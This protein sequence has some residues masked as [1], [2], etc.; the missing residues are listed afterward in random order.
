M[1]IEQLDLRPGR[2]DDAQAI[3]AMSRDLIEN[4]L[5]WSWTPGRVSRRLLH[6]ECATVVACQGPRL[7]AFGLMLLG[8]DIGHL[9][10]LAVEPQYQRRGLGRQ[11]F[12]WLEQTSRVAGL[13]RIDVEM[14]S[15]NRPARGFYRSLGFRETGSVP[16]YYSGLESATLMSLALRAAEPGPV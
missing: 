6:P 4:G 16:A 10:L 13:A 7:V 8:D 15:N 14:R 12:R 9:D 1:S 11:L 3:A 5:G 2:W